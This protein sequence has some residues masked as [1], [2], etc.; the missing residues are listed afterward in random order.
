VYLSRDEVSV[1][2]G[3]ALRHFL[4]IAHSNKLPVSEYKTMLDG[5]SVVIGDITIHAVS[6]P[7]HTAG[8]MCFLINNGIFVGDLCMIINGVIKPMLSI[9]TD[10]MAMDSASIRKIAAMNNFKTLYT[11]HSGYTKDIAKAFTA[12]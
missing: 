9:F 1:L 11:A 10:D 8:S 7:G 2:N 12:W 3:K 4:F 6:T 5:D